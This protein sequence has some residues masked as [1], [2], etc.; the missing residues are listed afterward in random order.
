MQIGNMDYKNLWKQM[1]SQGHLIYFMYYITIWK[2]NCQ[3][4]L[5]LYGK[6]VN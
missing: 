4:I 2:T 1:L 5:C 3:D 6:N